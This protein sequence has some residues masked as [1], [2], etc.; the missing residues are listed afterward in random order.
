M[1]ISFL[2]G[3]GIGILVIFTISTFFKAPAY[4]KPSK[5]GGGRGGPSKPTEIKP[6]ISREKF[7]TK[8]T[9]K[10][11]T[12]QQIKKTQSLPP[13][14]AKKVPFQKPVISPAHQENVKK[15]QSDLTYIKN[16]SEVTPEQK[17]QLVKDFQKLA[18]GTV[19]PSQESVSTLATSLSS[20]FADQ[21]ITP[22]EQIKI[23]ENVTT[24]MNSA[25]IPP[26]EVQAV[27]QDAK[28][29]LEASGVDKNDVE[30]IVND[31]KAI[32]EEIQNSAGT[33]T[34]GGDC[35]EN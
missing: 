12:M 18:E 25:N 28:T 24:V 13:E 10:T 3:M 9:N 32:V 1:I 31:L 27:V 15:L 5:G 21:K 22:Q 23:M 17:Q 26:E 35:S 6:S 30:I 34:Q 8:P 16:G 14:I 2:R 29:I 19:K 7:T 20:A 11:G 4:S 33:H